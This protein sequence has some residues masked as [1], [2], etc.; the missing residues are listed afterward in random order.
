METAELSAEQMA[1]LLEALPAPRRQRSGQILHPASRRESV[2]AAY[3]ALYGLAAGDAGSGLV[4]PTV[5]S[6]LTCSGEVREFSAKVGWPVGPHGKPF[7]D[8]L[9]CGRGRRYVS[10]SHSEGIVAA[11]VSDEPIGADIQRMPASAPEQLLRI[12]G[13]FH[14][15]ERAGLAQL[16]AEEIPAAFCRL[17][18]CKESVMKLCGRGLSLP[19]S[20]FCVE[21]EESELDGRRVRLQTHSV[22]SAVFAAAFWKEG[23]NPNAESRG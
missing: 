5:R 1:V 14:P 13:K 15:Y 21:G 2:A 23:V 12:A 16:A 9:L 10:L 20:S 11:A 3:L 18:A 6:L 8:G 19:L 4:F 17:W 22:G 7:A